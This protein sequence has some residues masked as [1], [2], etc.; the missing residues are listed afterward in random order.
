[1]VQALAGVWFVRR[2]VGARR[3]VAGVRPGVTL[4]K[5]LHGDEAGLEAALAS[6]LAL[7]Y[8]GFQVVF[9]VQDPDDAAL[10]V[11]ERLRLRFPS[12]DVAVVVDPALHGKN[13]KI[14]NLI[15]MLPEARYDILVISDADVHVAPDY[16]DHVVAALLAPGVGL[17]TSLYAGYSTSDTMAGKLAATAITHG[18]LPG[19]LTSRRLGNQDCL[20]A[21]MALKRETLEALGGFPA[22]VDHIADDYLLGVKVRGLGLSVAVAQTIPVTSVTETTLADLWRHEVRWART[23]RALVPV[24]FGLSVLQFE[25]AWALFAFCL[26]PDLESLSLFGLVWAV[27]AACGIAVDGML[28]GGLAT[29][30]PVWLLPVRDLLSFAITVASYTSN[31]V[32]WRGHTLHAAAL[33]HRAGSLGTE[34]T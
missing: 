34:L 33:P 18:F 23:I 31:R 25:M 27:A 20:G 5:P 16:L 30:V 15:N 12:V 10:A 3:S 9:G 2:F 26:D 7:A 24:Q 11:V 1:M 17:A 4:L 21:T 19:V 29:R 6:N 8:P 28:G 32:H 13:R 22:L 14:G